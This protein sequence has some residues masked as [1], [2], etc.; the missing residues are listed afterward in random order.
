MNFF[1]H[2]DQ[3]KK[4]TVRL[5][6]FFS[7]AVISLIALTTM[8]VA[9]FLYYFDL[10]NQKRHAP[11][12][13]ID[14][15][16]AVNI[17]QIVNWE[18]V[19]GIALVVITVVLIGSLYK[20]LQ[21]SGGGEKVAESLGGRRLQPNTDNPLERKLLNVVE[22]MA[23]AAGT[24]V[25]PVFVLEESG[26]NAFAAGYDVNDA[27]I[28]VTRGCLELLDRDELQGVIA[29]E[30]SH[31]L[32]GDMRINIR[33]I[34]ILHGILVIGL[35]GSLLMRSSA[36][37]SAYHA[38]RS[39]EKNGAGLALLGLGLVIIGY[40]GTFFGKLIKAAVSRQREFLAD[41]SAVQFTRNPDGISQAL[42][43]IGGFSQGSR[44][45]HPNAEEFSHLY[46]GE[47][48]SFSSLMATHPP[49]PTRIKRITPSWN[50]DYP[51]LKSSAARSVIDDSQTDTSAVHR[52]EGAV[53]GLA[54]EQHLEHRNATLDH[55]G[56]PTAAHIQ[57]ARQLLR[58]MPQALQDAAHE[59]FS[60]RALIYCLLLQSHSQ[61]TQ[62]EETQWQQLKQRAHPVVYK[63]TRELHSSVAQLH[64]SQ[65]LPLFELSIPALKTLS[66][67][68]YQVFK[69]NVVALI[70]A[71]RKVDVFEWAIYRMLLNSLESEPEQARYTTNLTQLA[72]PCQQLISTL[73]TAGHQRESE[74]EQ[75]YKQAMAQLGF[76]N[77]VLLGDGQISLP[78]LDSALAQLKSLKP[79]QKP[80]LLKAL[81]TCIQ[82]DGSISTSEYEMFRAIADCLNCP[83][84]PL[85]ED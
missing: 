13:A 82:H 31:I 73:A 77:L 10:Q 22:E 83:V 48:L 75:A 25:P 74:A 6:A 57:R 64:P 65:R 61:E 21:L 55:I 37:R 33:L 11:L 3:A 32:H 28:G 19:S 71:D 52:P 8:L 66:E 40:A 36:T 76:A 54:P 4:N 81:L 38:N 78:L 2:Q 53:S 59:P 39:R 26:I 7:L 58:D 17:A 63:L 5:I 23:I 49:L 12:Q 15:L 43:K 16:N 85:L 35:L 69:A 41:A 9:G 72:V 20:L 29:H 46:F 51:N 84:P 68:Q 44:L 14:G 79:L 24:P 30:F 50:G 47:G 60:A 67:P 42:Q 34:G 70:R 62:T 18:L 80:A 56:A 1:E 45:R 27:V